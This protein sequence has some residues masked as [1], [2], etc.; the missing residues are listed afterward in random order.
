MYKTKKV[1]I[2]HDSFFHIGGAERVFLSLI[3]LFPDSDLYIPLVSKKYVNTINKYRNKSKIVSSPFNPLPISGKYASLLK[4]FIFWYWEHLDLPDYDLVISSSH[5]F[6]SKSVMTKPETLHISYIHTPPKYLYDEYNEMQFI[7]KGIIKIILTPLMNYLRKLDFFGAQ[8]PDILIAN[9][10]NVQKRIK[11]Y[12]GRKSIIIY[13]PVK[14]PKLVKPK[15]NKEYYLFFSRLV[16]Q[17]GA[18]LAIKAFNNLGQQLVV[19][20]TGPEERRLKIMARGNIVFKGYV[21]D[22][23]MQNVYSRAKALIYCSIDEDF[24]IVPVESMSFGVPVIAYNS[25]GVAGTVVDGKTGLMFDNYSTDDLQK[26]VLKFER[27]EF[28]LSELKKH[29]LKFSEEQFNKKF[30]KLVNIYLKKEKLQ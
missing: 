30:L 4:P 27:M 11:K 2:I 19:V 25:G 1:A 5:S 16:K 18:R 24:G 17:K 20:G 22:R 21:S 29:A 15:K 9:S 3:K 12:Y 14:I 7:N 13:P 26:A 8:R 10:K 28:S 6:S 23:K